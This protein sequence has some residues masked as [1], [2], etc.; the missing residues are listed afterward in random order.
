[1]FP[2]LYMHSHHQQSF[3]E[4]IWL[5]SLFLTYVLSF[6]RVLS[7]Y[8]LIL[9]VYVVSCLHVF[10][11]TDRFL[12]VAPFGICI[13]TSKTSVCCRGRRSSLRSTTTASS[14]F[15]R[16]WCPPLT[17]SALVTW[18]R[19]C[20]LC[21]ALSSLLV[22]PEWGRWG[23]FLKKKYIYIFALILNSSTLTTPKWLILQNI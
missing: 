10:P 8:L 4:C 13:W 17:L 9:C 16:C 21:A 15:L 11:S 12:K 22:A 3:R 6:L 20:S 5:K 2:H 18:W 14:P 23:L 7:L 19:S 1:M